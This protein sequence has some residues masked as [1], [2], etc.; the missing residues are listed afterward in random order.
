MGAE[1]SIDPL[2]G[3]NVGESDHQYKTNSKVYTASSA[4]SSSQKKDVYIACRVYWACPGKDKARRKAAA[5]RRIIKEKDV[6]LF[7]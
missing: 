3:K 5:K 1:E 7:S 6:V 4:A 2:S